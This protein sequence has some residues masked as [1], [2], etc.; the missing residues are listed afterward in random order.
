MI[1]V[2]FKALT[3]D[4]SEESDSTDSLTVTKEALVII[5]ILY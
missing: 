1:P 5:S 2:K 4:S 3:S